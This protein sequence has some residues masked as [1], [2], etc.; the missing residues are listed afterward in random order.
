MRKLFYSLVI[1]GALTF[2]GCTL[3]Q[4]VKMA[5]EQQLTVNPNPLEVHKDTVVFDM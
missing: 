3:P 2:T 5:K 4:M 1:V